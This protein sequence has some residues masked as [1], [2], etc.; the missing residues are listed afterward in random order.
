M[1][2]LIFTHHAIRNTNMP[3]IPSTPAQDGFYMP[4]E[5]APHA[6]CWMLWPERPDVW[7]YHGDAAQKVFANVA[8]TIARFEPVTMG[9]SATQFDNARR[10]LPDSVRVLR[11]DYNDAWVRDNGPT[12]VINK[13]GE[14][15]GVDWD[16]NAWG[17]LYLNYEADRALARQI[18]AHEKVGRYQA[19]LIMEGGALHVDGEGTLLVVEN[20]L[21]HP[22]RNPQLTQSDIE[23]HLRNYLNVQTII[24]L[25]EGIHGD[26]TDGHVD[27]L[28]CFVRPG[29]VALT[30]TDDA[31]D[32][33]YH[34]SREAYQ[35]LSDATDAQGRSLEIHRI[36]QP[37]PMY[38]SV[39]EA[40]GL[41][42]VPGHFT[43]AV[44][45]RMAGSYIN[46]YVAN[47]GVIVP[48]FNDV[49]DQAALDTLQTL[50]P[51]REVV[52][53][54]SREIL[55]GG[56]NIHCITQQQPRGVSG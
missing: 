45:N 31:D 12:F 2:K 27:N 13:Q 10:L 43:R 11:L 9:V 8:A 41:V 56:G 19:P 4:A 24:W 35:H 48:Q 1:R 50:Y 39:E 51:D 49:H 55:I 6:G 34:I 32:L 21:L 40:A 37:T 52:G 20:C 42:Q 33:Q 30:W 47:G 46:Y 17:E 22:N 7:P 18:L 26:E 28:C 29:V 44:D 25:P 54:Y 14:V 3:P 53:V 23:Q 5:F 36:H 15:R 16:F 38:V